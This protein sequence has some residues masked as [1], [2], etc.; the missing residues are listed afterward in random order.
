MQKYKKKKQMIT[1][2]LYQQIIIAQALFKI[3]K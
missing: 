3:N 2:H 1:L